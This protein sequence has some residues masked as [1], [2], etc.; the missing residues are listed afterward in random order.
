M[1]DLKQ[2]LKKACE[3]ESQLPQQR[4]CLVCGMVFK[5][6]TELYPL[7]NV[8]WASNDIRPGYGIRVPGGRMVN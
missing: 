3:K 2:Q 1:K 6:K 8:C 5:T 7:C 4:R